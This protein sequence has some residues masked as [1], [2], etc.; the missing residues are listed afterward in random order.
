MPLSEREQQILDELERELTGARRPDPATSGSKQRE[1]F[2]GLKI[3]V[4]LIVVGVVMLMWF[5]TNPFLLLGVAAFALMVGG[6]VLGASSV[7]SEVGHRSPGRRI[8]DLV[9]GWERSIRRRDQDED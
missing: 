4:L 5:F 8:S 1:R 7:R 6:I 9:G 3:G 2:L